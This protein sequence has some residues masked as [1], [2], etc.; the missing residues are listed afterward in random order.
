[1]VENGEAHLR[2][3]EVGQRTPFAAEI[4]SGLA[5]DATVIVHPSNQISDG[6]RVEAQEK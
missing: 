6:V 5:E 4:K 3:V 2:E 1:V